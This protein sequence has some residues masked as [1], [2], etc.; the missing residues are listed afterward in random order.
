MFMGKMEEPHAQPN[1]RDEKHHSV[2]LVETIHEIHER[3]HANDAL[4][5]RAIQGSKDSIASRYA[6]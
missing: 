2:Q 1:A 3:I 4:Y 5:M 6:L